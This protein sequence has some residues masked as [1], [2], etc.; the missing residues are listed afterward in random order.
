MKKR[1]NVTINKLAEKAHQLKLSV[2][3]S[4]VIIRSPNKPKYYLDT[5]FK[6]D[7]LRL[8]VSDLVIFGSNP[9]HQVLAPGVYLLRRQL[10]KVKVTN[11]AFL[12]HPQKVVSFDVGS[13]NL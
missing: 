1:C 7:L 12:S 5:I 9:A 11:D 4:F 8:Q 6:V 3:R 10:P 2:H 13:L